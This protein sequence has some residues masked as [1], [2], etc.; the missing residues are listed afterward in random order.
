MD[1]NQKQRD[2][3]IT[4]FRDAQL[5]RKEICRTTNIPLST[6][7]RIVKSLIETGQSPTIRTGRCGRRKSSSQQHDG[8]ILRTSIIN[9]RLTAVDI[10]HH[11]NSPLLVHTIRR[12]L[13]EG[14]RIATKP[15]KKPLLTA[16][17]KKA[18]FAW[19]VAHR[20]WTANNWR[21]VCRSLS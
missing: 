13:N 2:R 10:K 8:M 19:G 21:K 6:V 9:P 3:I 20:N 4:L 1:K 5:S 11:L 17:K 7:R 16:R 14:G 15:I 18:T 12:R